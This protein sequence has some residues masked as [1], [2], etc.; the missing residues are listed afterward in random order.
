MTLYCGIDLHS[1]N[2]LVSIIDEHDRIVY[3]K[4][5]ANDLATIRQP[6]LVYQDQLAGVVVES[7]YNWYWL[8]D[9]LS[10]SGFDVRLAN[11]VALKQYNGLKYT[12]DKT[13]AR[14][15]AHLLRLGILPEGYVLPF[16]T[17]CV[18][19]LFRRRLL[20]VRQ[21]VMQH[22][23]LQSLITR[24][25]GQRLT[26][27]RVRALKVEDLSTLV[28]H[29]SAQLSARIAHEL[30]GSLGEAIERI[31]RN[32]ARFC[33]P[34]PEQAVIR[35]ITGIGPILGQSIVLETGPI[36]RFASVNNYAS[37]ARCVP[38]QKI[39]NGKKKGEGNRKN[40]NKYL[41]YAFMEAAH[42]AA[43]W[44]PKIKRYY[45]RKAQ[46]THKMVAKKAVANKL[47]KACYHMLTRN[48]PFD[49]NRAFA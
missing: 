14:Y 43:I 15:L 31:E 47:A 49:V 18:R 29:P 30:I 19:D 38:S 6:L 28:S 45:Q 39:S 17:R 26:G 35:S 32:V 20:L 1:N 40:G 10:A 42:Y 33:Q 11:T 27:P 7:T 48:E 16:D 24:H 36:E 5:L 23:S 21:R 34:L 4:R 37:Y 22:L 25:T 41:E 12:D 8:V 2:S 46:R 9:G 13:D 3:E 44:E